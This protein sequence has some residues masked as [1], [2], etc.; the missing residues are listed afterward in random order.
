MDPKEVK[1]KSPK[2][3]WSW[4]VIPIVFKLYACT[5]FLTSIFQRIP[6]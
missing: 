1:R 5:W 3:I 4:G 2:F 6:R